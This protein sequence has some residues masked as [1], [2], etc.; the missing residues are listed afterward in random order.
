MFEG[1]IDWSIA[2][3]E[4]SED[5]GDSQV[6]RMGEEIY[7]HPN[8]EAGWAQQT[9]KAHMLFMIHRDGTR[10]LKM[11][12]E[13]FAAR[14]PNKL[15]KEKLHNQFSRLKKNRKRPRRFLLKLHGLKQKQVV[16][17]SADSWSVGFP[18]VWSPVLTMFLHQKARRQSQVRAQFKSLQGREHNWKFAP[19]HQS[20]EESE[21]NDPADIWHTQTLPYMTPDVRHMAFWQHSGN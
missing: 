3:E 14:A 11:T 16:T 15:V 13:E 6:I 5:G 7:I 18:P 20:S 4:L 1:M 9:W 2:T 21:N 10:E 12:K 8:F 19:N 17:I